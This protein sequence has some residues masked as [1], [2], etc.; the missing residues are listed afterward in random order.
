ML[1][2][3]VVTLVHLPNKVECFGFVRNYDVDHLACFLLLIEMTTECDNVGRAGCPCLI[4]SFSCISAFP[5]HDLA[6]VGSEMTEN[7]FDGVVGIP[8]ILFVEFFDVLFFGVI[9]TQKCEY[10]YY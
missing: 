2:G 3:E 8:K 10:L 9:P 4:E 7:T 5:C 6:P 1:L